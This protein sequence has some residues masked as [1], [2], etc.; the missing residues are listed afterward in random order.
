MSHQQGETEV[1]VDPQRIA[2]LDLGALDTVDALGG[3]VVAL[4]KKGL[5]KSLEKYQ[6]E[7]YT[8]L[9]T[10]KEIDV[11]ALNEADPDVILVGGRTAEK[12]PEFAEIAPS[13][14]VTLGD[15]SFL[16]SLTKQT[17]TIAQVLGAEDEA[18]DKLAD[19]ETKID[20]VSAKAKRS[21]DAM[22]VMVSGGKMSAFGP[23]SRFGLIHDEL[24][25]TPTVEDI[26]HEDGHGQAISFEF[27]ADKKPEHLFVIDRDAAVG[28]EGKSAEQVLDNELVHKTPA[29]KDEKV[30]YLDATSWY[31]LGS[32][33]NNSAAMIDEVATALG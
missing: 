1:P 29:W 33:L 9:G 16:E 13:L 8:D 26:K 21:G 32:G 24:G 19:I 18:K 22:I 23:G 25:V 11:E 7:D 10:V 20:E 17:N 4:P 5:P 30:T 3:E 6:G 2:V 28:D 15:G 27:L 31:I 12:Y 14:D